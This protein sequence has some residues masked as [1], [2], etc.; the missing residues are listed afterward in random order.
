MFPPLTATR[1]YG[2]VKPPP[3]KTKKTKKPKKRMNMS[4]S[5]M[6]FLGPESSTRSFRLFF[7]A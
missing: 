1:K 2:I 3:K 7:S 4:E 5:N 6:I